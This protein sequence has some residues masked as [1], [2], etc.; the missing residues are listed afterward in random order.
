[1]SRFGNKEWFARPSPLMGGDGRFRMQGVG[2][3]WAEN[4]SKSGVTFSTRAGLYLWPASDGLTSGTGGLVMSVV[5]MTTDRFDAEV[6]G[7]D[8]PVLVDFYADWCPPCRALAPEL[9]VLAERVGE[10]ARVVKVHIEREPDLAKR[11]DVASIPTVLVISDGKVVQRSNGYAD[12]DA[13]ERMLARG[14]AEVE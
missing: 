7:S 11:Y 14:G 13:L 8:L 9:D 12:A 6:L 2:G 10:A 3:A 5:S 4:F 1:M